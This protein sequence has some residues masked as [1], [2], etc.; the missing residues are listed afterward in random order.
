MLLSDVDDWFVWRKCTSHSLIGRGREDH[1]NNGLSFHWH[2][3]MSVH[4]VIKF[5][6][7]FCYKNM[8]VKG[9]MILYNALNLYTYTHLT[10]ST[11]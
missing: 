10:V 6:H 11:Q 7:G 9:L 5:N 4:Y 8:K 1:V 2:V 3:S